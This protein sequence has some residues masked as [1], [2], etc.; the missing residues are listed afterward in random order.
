MTISE[1]GIGSELDSNQN[2]VSPQ[3]LDEVVEV[4]AFANRGNKTLSIQG[5]AT[6][7]RYQPYVTKTDITLSSSS[8]DKLI[9]H[10]PSDMTA[11]IQSGVSIA[12]IQKSLYQFGQWLAI[13]PPMW[14][15][16]ATLGGVV[17]AGHAGPSR[18]KFGS[19]KD[20]VIGMTAVLGDGRVIRCGGNV[21][22][23][24]AGYDLS[25]IFC[26]SW[27]TLAFIVDVTLRL[28]PLAESKR[29]L[30]AKLSWEQA[31]NFA[32]SLIASPFDP[33]AIEIGFDHIWI[34]LE[35]SSIGTSQRA[36]AIAQ[37][38]SNSNIEIQNV[39]ISQAQA[40]FDKFSQI[41]IATEEQSI[42]KASILPS[43]LA[44]A[45][46]ELDNLA[47]K[48]AIDYQVVSHGGSGIVL[49]KLSS[50]D[51]HSHGELV[52]KWRDYL[53]G[54]GGTMIVEQGQ[55]GLQELVSYWG[56]PPGGFKVMQRI[57]EEFDPKPIL[58]PGGF[59]GWW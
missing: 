46:E 26:G 5:N 30:K 54:L 1:S 4:I 15:R 6:K 37:M 21:I 8:L 33:T 17:A 20:L 3:N 31:Q 45:V 28:H 29:I 53:Q 48:I 14:D 2:R 47:N 16:G 50:G 9:S 25:K 32:L 44:K 43:Q 13:D 58:T 55:N 56:N 12:Q 40:V 35:G 51:L 52:K 10:N 49:A 18:V 19:I 11:T 41:R 59:G 23:N 22:K 39:E 42:L 36:N 34:V 24:V 57:K 38:A 27:G 7:T